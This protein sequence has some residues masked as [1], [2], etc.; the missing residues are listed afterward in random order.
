MIGF[1]DIEFAE[2]LGLTTVRQPLAETGADA[3][4]LLIA[5]ITRRRPDPVEIVH[6]LTLIQ[7]RTT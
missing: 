3:I 6:P 1:D 4:E 5:E 7:R 2:I